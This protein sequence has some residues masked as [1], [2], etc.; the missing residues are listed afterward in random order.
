[1]LIILAD[2]AI[3]CEIVAL[4]NMTGIARDK[5]GTVDGGVAETAFRLPMFETGAAGGEK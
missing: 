4:K 1:M 2:L 5:G 3:R